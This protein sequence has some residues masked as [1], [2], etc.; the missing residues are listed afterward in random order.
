LIHFEVDLISIP[1][2]TF[3]YVYTHF[4]RFH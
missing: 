1:E 4:T 2:Q 3:T